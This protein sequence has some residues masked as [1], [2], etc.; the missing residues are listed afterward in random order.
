MIKQIATPQ[1]NCHQSAHTDQSK[2][3]GKLDSMLRHFAHGKRLNRFEA[4]RLGDH[5][6]HTTISD[7]Q[8][9]HLIRFN[10]TWVKVPNR[11]GSK[12]RVMSYWLDGEDLARANQ[13]ISVG[14]QHK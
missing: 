6:L 3:I 1:P 7:L 11:F 13:I 9:R 8:I 2:T 4:E 14:G 10:R 12:T 5:C